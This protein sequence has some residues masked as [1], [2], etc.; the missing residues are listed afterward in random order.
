MSVAK[1]SMCACRCG[2]QN[3]YLTNVANLIR[4]GSDGV[5]PY[6]SPQAS[7]LISAAQPEFARHCGA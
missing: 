2:R 7:P 6:T 1:T 4:Y 5:N 3:H